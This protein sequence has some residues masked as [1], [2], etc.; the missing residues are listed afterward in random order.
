[1]P[2][3]VDT[4]A[5]AQAAALAISSNATGAGVIAGVAQ[6]PV[7]FASAP[8]LLQSIVTALVAHAGSFANLVPEL[9]GK[10]YFENLGTVYTGAL[11]QSVLD[12]VN[13]SVGRFDASP[14]ALNQMA[15]HYEPTGALAMPMLMLST[16]RDPVVPG[17]HQAKYQQLATA[18]GNGSRLAQRTVTR[19]GHCNFTPDELGGAFLSLVAWVEFGVPPAP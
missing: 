9:H 8:E 11:P 10:S 13:A 18:A 6:T 12:L 4:A 3:D 15:Q 14:S 19:Y 17:F 16:S 5:V 1:V 2:P 7:P